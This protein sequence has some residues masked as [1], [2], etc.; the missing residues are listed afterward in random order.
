[1]K[2]NKVADVIL[3]RAAAGGNTDAFSELAV[4]YQKRIKAFG[5]SFFHNETDADD[6][7]QDVLI[8]I[9]TKLS[10]FRGDSQFSTWLMRIAYNTAINSL[11]RRKEYVPLS[12]DFELMDNDLSPEDRQMRAAVVEAVRETMKEIPVH[13]SV[14]LDLYFFYGMA[15]NEISIITDLPVNTVKSHIFRAKKLM[16]QKLEDRI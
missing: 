1:M 6:F 5:M 4:R 11:N 10:T 13:F 14:C 9:Y 15:Y 16:K 2:D 7:V 8:K 3:V 12:E